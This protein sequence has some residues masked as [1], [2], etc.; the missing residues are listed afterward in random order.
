MLLKFKFYYKNLNLG[1]KILILIIK[2]INEGEIKV[3]NK[4]QDTCGT[5]ASIVAFSNGNDW[6]FIIISNYNIYLNFVY[7]PYL[8][9][10]CKCFSIVF[11]NI[12]IL[13]NFH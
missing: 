9:F 10:V 4:A 1:E 8:F 11:L 7:I 5:N 13:E 12:P 3:G 2:K 6:N